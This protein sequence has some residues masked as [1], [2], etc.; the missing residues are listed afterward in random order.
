MEMV[1]GVV[2]DDN[3]SRGC[4]EVWCCDKNLVLAGIQ[5]QCSRHYGKPA[6]SL[7][8][9]QHQSIWQPLVLEVVKK[10]GVAIKIWLLQAYKNSAVGI[11]TNWHIP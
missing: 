1:G 4:Q 6:Y 5:K 3:S 9:L 10:F 11:M 7:E 8:P 2:K